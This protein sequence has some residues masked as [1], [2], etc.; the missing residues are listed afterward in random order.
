MFHVKQPK[1]KGPTKWAGTQLELRNIIEAKLAELRAELSKT[2]AAQAE[3]KED[4]S[5]GEVAAGDE[6]GTS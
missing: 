3:V 6:E 4:L 2:L 1:L 5:G